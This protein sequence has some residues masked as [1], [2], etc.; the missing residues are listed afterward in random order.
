[1]IYARKNGRREIIVCHACDEFTLRANIMVSTGN[2]TGNDD[3]HYLCHF[4][5]WYI[6]FW[7]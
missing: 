5:F 2:I 3:I 4:Q 6:G 7:Y 1:M